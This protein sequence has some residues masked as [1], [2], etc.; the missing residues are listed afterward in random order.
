MQDFVDKFLNGK[1]FD[2]TDNTKFSD[3]VMFIFIIVALVVG[4]IFSLIYA[5]K[6]TFYS[7]NI[8]LGIGL[9]VVAILC[10]S[11]FIVFIVNNNIY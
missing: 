10:A 7:N 4:F 6:Y 8:L 5:I 9:F 3:L 11:P 1:K 2:F